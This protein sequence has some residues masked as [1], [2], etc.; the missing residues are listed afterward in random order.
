MTIAIDAMGGDFAPRNPILGA[1]KAVNENGLNVVLVGDEP[2]IKKILNECRVDNSKIEIVHASQA[3]GMDEPIASAL[4]SKK[5][6]SLRICFDLHKKGD[7]NGVV[8][9]GNSGAMMAI[10]RYVLKMIPGIHRPCISAILPSLNEKVL[11]VDA[12]ANTECTP[13]HLFQFAVL[14][15]VYMKHFHGLDNPRIGLLNVGSEEGKGNERTKKT[16]DLLKQTSLN[17]IGNIEGK[18]FFNG[19]VDIVVTD[20][21]A[22]NILLKSVQAAASFVTQVFEQ[23]IKQSLLMKLGAVLMTPVFKRWKQSIDY[24]KYGGAPLLGLKGNGVVCH[25]RSNPEALLFGINFAKWA[26]DN[27]LVARMEEKTVEFKDILNQKG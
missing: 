5:D 17:F 15:F 19:H 2:G 16:F 9:A 21:F 11:L 20:G 24:A 26:A 25:G 4:R 3:V 23:E 12:G 22:G 7:V 10:G 27:H 14:G 6:S 8:S 1:V 13:K 18:E